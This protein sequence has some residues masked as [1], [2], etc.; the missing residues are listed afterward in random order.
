[1]MIEFIERPNRKMI[2]AQRI[3]RFYIRRE[4]SEKLEPGQEIVRSQFL[5]VMMPELFVNHFETCP[6]AS[7]FSRKAKA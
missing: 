5:D 4:N 1:M 6:Q 3:R 2:P 7:E